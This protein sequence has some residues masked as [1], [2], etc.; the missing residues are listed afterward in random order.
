M[1]S[2]NFMPRAGVRVFSLATLAAGAALVS[3]AANAQTALTVFN[4]NDATSGAAAGTQNAALFSSDG[5]LRTSTIT[6]T[7]DT[8]TITNFAGTTVNAQSGDAA[9]QALALVGGTTANPS[10]NNGARI[11]FSVSTVGFNS[12][13]VSYATQ[14]TNTGFT[15]QELFYSLNGTTFTSAGTFT[16]IPTAFVAQTFNLSGV[17]G[18][19]DNANATFRIVFN[20]ATSAGGNNRIDNLV[21]SG[22]AT[23]GAVAP[24]P[25]A[26]VLALAGLM[27]MA[28]V[29]ARRRK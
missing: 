16:T 28:G 13:V 3:S 29:A 2:L 24:E 26:G 22:T 25:G 7:F 4:F 5:G 10:V 19:N 1:T 9:G 27:G 14:R 8:T 12:I 20:G 6:T 15:S 21:V 23:G 17:T 18:L 11:Q